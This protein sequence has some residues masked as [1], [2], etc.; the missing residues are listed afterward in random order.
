[1]NLETAEKFIYVEK[2]VDMLPPEP[3]K[4]LKE[5]MTAVQNEPDEIISRTLDAIRD[6]LGDLGIGT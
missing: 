3:R 4:R 5:K 1:M 6:T 2:A